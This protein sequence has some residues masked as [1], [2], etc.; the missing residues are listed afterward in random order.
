MSTTEQVRR[1]M[2]R[3]EASLPRLMTLYRDRWV[4]FRDGEVVSAHDTEG[5]IGP[6]L[7][8]SAATAATSLRR[9]PSAQFRSAAVTYQC[10]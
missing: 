4:V 6:V 5:R 9:S 1:E 3:F 7:Q 10:G 8:G 2:R